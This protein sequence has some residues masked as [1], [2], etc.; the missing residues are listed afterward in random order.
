[1]ANCCYN[2]PWAIQSDYEGS[3]QWV[4]SCYDRQVYGSAF[5]LKR[6]AAQAYR[7]ERWINYGLTGLGT[8]AS[9]LF[10]ILFL[11][12]IYA[13]YEGAVLPMSPLLNDCTLFSSFL[14]IRSFNGVIV[15][16]SLFST[17]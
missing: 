3:T 12:W 1:M 9:T 6:Q 16:L 11:S 5:K 10:M 13:S 2:E 15:I 17:I 8:I 14:C 4:I 7:G